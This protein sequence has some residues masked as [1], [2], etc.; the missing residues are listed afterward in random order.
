M[1]QDKLQDYENAFS[2][3]IG[4]KDAKLH[5]ASA[6][7]S[8]RHLIISGP[9][10]IG[11]TSIAKSIAKLLGE[12]VVN[13]CGYHCDPQVPLCPVCVHAAKEGR[14]MPTTLLQ[15]EERFIRIQGSPDLTAEDLIDEAYRL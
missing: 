1:I 13:D 12:V 8:Q 11:K 7:I 6:L 9:P 15:P 3:I 5:I 14:N 2:G 10:G 4:Q